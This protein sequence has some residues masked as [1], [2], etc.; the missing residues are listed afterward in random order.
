MAD[1]PEMHGLFILHASQCIFNNYYRLHLLVISPKSLDVRCELYQNLFGMGRVTEIR[2]WIS[3]KL[4]IGATQSE[5][6]ALARFSF[7]FVAEREQISTF[8]LLDFTF[9]GECHM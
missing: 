4:A 2:F 6:L 1:E 5:N 3:L 9:P 7:C 8:F